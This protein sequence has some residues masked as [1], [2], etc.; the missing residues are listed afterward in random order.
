MDDDDDDDDDDDGNEPQPI[1]ALP[2]HG[3]K[4]IANCAEAG[5]VKVLLV[6]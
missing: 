4:L 3:L 1:P 2:P 5:I 6:E